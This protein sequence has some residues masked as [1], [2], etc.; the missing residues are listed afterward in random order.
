VA[1]LQWSESAGIGRYETIWR[2]QGA[3]FGYQVTSYRPA[4]PSDT[5]FKVEEFT[6]HDVQRRV[7][8]KGTVDGAK[9][10]AQDWEDGWQ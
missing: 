10:M 9:Q 5:G 7:D 8:H 6:P 1:T 2:A 4:A 3:K